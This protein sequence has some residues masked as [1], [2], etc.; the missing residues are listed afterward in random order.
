VSEHRYVADFGPVR[1]A[2]VDAD[3]AMADH[4]G[5]LPLLEGGDSDGVP[6]AWTIEGRLTEPEEGMSRT[7]Q[8][9]GYRGDRPAR[10]LL[11]CST[12]PCHLAVAVRDAVLEVL[13]DYCEARGCTMLRA[14]AV[15]DDQR[16]VI[17]AGGRGDGKT[18]L[19]LSAVADGG[20]W[21]L[22]DDELILY[23]TEQGLVLASVPTVTPGRA[24]PAHIALEGRNTT[25][26]LARYAPAGESVS[27]RWV[28]DPEQEMWRYVRF[29]LAFGRQ[30]DA[31]FLPRAERSRGTFA[32]DTASRLAELTEATSLALHWHH[33]GELAPLLDAVR[34]SEEGRH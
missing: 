7:P 14:S 4:L 15:V 27:A 33:H 17:V 13:A 24:S 29:D 10:H 26:V 12:D 11:I 20:H 22:S 23:R 2:V 9:V 21:I 1:A 18:T 5:D 25:I 8:Q 6:V 19:A 28:T 32:R 30:A 31:S 34:D 3:D 16:V